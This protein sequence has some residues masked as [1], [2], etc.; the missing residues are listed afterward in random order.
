LPNE[1]YRKIFSLVTHEK[2]RTFED[3]FHRTVMATFLAHVIKLGGFF[4]AENDDEYD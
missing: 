2:A 4:E 3:I 1:D